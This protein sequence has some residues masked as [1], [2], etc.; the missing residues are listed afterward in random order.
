MGLFFIKVEPASCKR[1]FRKFM[2]MG[3]LYL[4]FLS[5]VA[6]CTDLSVFYR[7]L[8]C[9]IGTESVRKDVQIFGNLRKYTDFC[10][11]RKFRNMF[12]YHLQWLKNSLMLTMQCSLSNAYSLLASSMNIH[13]SLPHWITLFASS[14][15]GEQTVFTK[16]NSYVACKVDKL[17]YY[18]RIVYSLGLDNDLDQSISH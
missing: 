1:H 8:R 11:S 7:F 5:R 13:Q 14:T 2:C 4:T 9:L 6:T 3:T 12:E 10:H 17:S 16:T 15:N 18:W